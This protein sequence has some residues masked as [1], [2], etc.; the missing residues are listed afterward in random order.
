MDARDASWIVATHVTTLNQ[1]F[2]L[3]FTAALAFGAFTTTRRVLRYRRRRESLPRL[4]VRDVIVRISLA[5]PFLLILTVRAIGRIRGVEIDMSEELWWSLV[6]GGLA[7]VGALVYDYYEVVIERS[8][9]VADLEQQA[10][11]LSRQEPPRT[12]AGRGDD[13]G[14]T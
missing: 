5:V 10:R 8:E 1:V 6:T 11:A 9:Q 7:V 3:A 13:P 14:L 12:R 4:L 2:L